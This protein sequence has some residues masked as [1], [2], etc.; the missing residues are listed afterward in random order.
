VKSSDYAKQG[1]LRVGPVDL[2][3]KMKACGKANCEGCPH[4]PFW[5]GYIPA[6]DSMDQTRVEVYLGRLWTDADLRTNVAPK[7][8]LT[9]RREFLLAIETVV[10]S[11]R[12]AWLE[13]EEA[14]VGQSIKDVAARAQAD[15]AK[16]RRD[17]AVV[18]K[19]LHDLRS[20]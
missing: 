2:I 10:C 14:A 19:E 13:R 11:E 5:Y 17:E 16:L 20:K 12:I 6:F 8:L 4:G 15:I 1:R 9:S 3:G 18:K 7:M